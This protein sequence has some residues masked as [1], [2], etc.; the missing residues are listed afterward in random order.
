MC[1]RDG[2]L[3]LTRNDDSTQAPTVIVNNT[4]RAYSQE[5]KP[6]QPA[7]QTPTHSEI[8]STKITSQQEKIDQLRQIKQ[9]LDEGILT[10]EEFNNQKTAILG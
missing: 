6:E 10:Q 8:T 4:S 1:N 2:Y 7:A 5:Y 9:L 3:S